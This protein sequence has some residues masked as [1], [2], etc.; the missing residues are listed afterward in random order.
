MC[1]RSPRQAMM[2]SLRLFCPAPRFAQDGSF[3]MLGDA[4]STVPFVSA[5]PLPILKQR[6]R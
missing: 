2:E 1:S 5:A 3:S 6:W 4:L